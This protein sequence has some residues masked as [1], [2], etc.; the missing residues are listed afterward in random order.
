MLW[1]PDPRPRPSTENPEDTRACG[2]RPM[3]CEGKACQPVG[4]TTT[5]ILPAL[6]AAVGRKPGKAD[7]G[8]GACEAEPGQ[9]RP[10]SG[11]R[12]GFWGPQGSRDGSRACKASL[13]PCGDSSVTT[14][15]GL[16]TSSSA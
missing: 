12:R 8:G 4:V 7:Q 14:V 15:G 9:S 10:E 2:F 5:Y 11:G 6:G 3:A 1:S 13:R 16:G